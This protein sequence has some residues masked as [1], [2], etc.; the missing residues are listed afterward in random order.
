MATNLTD[1]KRKRRQPDVR[2]IK[3]HSDIMRRHSGNVLVGGA[4][5]RTET[6]FIVPGYRGKN[7]ETYFETMLA[8]TATATLYHEKKDRVLRVISGSFFVIIEKDGEQK[9]SRAIPG[10]ELVFERGTSYRL[11]TAGEDIEFFV[12]QSPKYAA[13]LEVSGQPVI[14]DVPSHL[15]QAP[16]QSQ[17]LNPNL[18][19]AGPG[20]RGSKAKQQLAKQAATRRSAPASTNEPIPGREGH[21]VADHA[22]AATLGVSPQPSMGKE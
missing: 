22:P 9:Q 7:F 17:R 12:V 8:G 19:K 18:P 11:A 4:R 3:K 10:D 20:R 6:G 21:P 2:K 5:E 16:T 14:S 1:L 13:T 15:L